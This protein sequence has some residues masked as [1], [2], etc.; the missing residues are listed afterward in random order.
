MTKFSIPIATAIVLFP[1]IALLITVP[2][3]VHKYRKLGSVPLSHA[4]IVYSFVF[5][6]MCAYFLVLLPLPADRTAYV[7]Y[8]ATPQL[9]PFYFLR[10]FS[11]ITTA[12]IADFTT[13]IQVVTKPTI[14]EAFF[15]VLLL[16]PLGAYLRYYFKRTWWQ[17]LIIGFLVSLSFELTQLTGIWGIYEHPYRLFDVDDLI[18]NT[19]G[20]MLG[21]WLT[22]PIMRILPDMRIVERE[23]KRRGR[24]ASA[25][26]RALSFVI[27]LAL[28]AALALATFV[29]TKDYFDT[30]L[31][32]DTL[33]QSAFWVSVLFGLVVTFA[34]IPLITKGQTV[35][36][37]MLNLQVVK[38]NLTKASWLT[39]AGRY[40]VLFVLL[41]IPTWVF[42]QIIGLSSM[43]TTTGELKE[44]ASSALHGPRVLMALW[45]IGILTWAASLI[46]RAINAAKNN[47]ELIMLNG[48]ITN[49][50]V[51]TLDGLNR[52][53]AKHRVLTVSEV[54]ALEQ[55]LA[56]SGTPLDELMRRAGQAVAAEVQAY[57]PDPAPVVILAGSGNNGG[58]GWVCGR[59]LATAGWPVTLITPKIHE[60]ITAEP[61]RSESIATIAETSANQTPFK[62]LVA[63][64]PEALAAELDNAA[65]IVDAMLGTGFEGESVREPYATWINLANK[66]RFVGYASSR[67]NLLTSS[68]LPINSRNTQGL[69][70]AR[71]T[72]KAKEAP[73]ALAVDTPSGLSA[74][75]GNAALP[76][77]YADE[78]ITMLAFKPG[79]LKRGS[80][81]ITGQVEL[82][83]LVSPDMWP[84]TV[85]E[86]TTTQ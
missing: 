81:R 55:S 4:L 28:A 56:Q 14:Y 59:I 37:K 7:A 63:P 8:A 80:A 58:D 82:A 36:Q 71:F 48:I 21:F 16:L 32:V 79:L 23:A 39:V 77:F 12:N 47:E 29:V 51:M 9:Q 72:Q 34:L 69:K 3:M 86:C 75:T 24:C 76:R 74:Q 50:R 26:R 41:L 20:A 11:A 78:T 6:L 25:T 83:E 54:V 73:F 68:R 66:R 40:T 62:V 65:A 57:V 67:K 44:V 52:A 60:L 43:P 64:E 1:F 17:T 18:T 22:G 31:F 13:W 46:I 33:R 2:F 35:G 38:T 42:S 70:H 45:G 61:A 84:D 19:F 49:T 27:D 5:Y 30:N 85:S 10:A 53:Q 15:N